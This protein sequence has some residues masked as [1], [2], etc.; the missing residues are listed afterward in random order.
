MG[1]PRYMTIMLVP[2]GTESGRTFRIR[3]WLLRFVIGFAIVL[4]VG[5]VLFFSFYGKI[6]ARAAMAD[7]LQ[8]ENQKLLRYQYKVKLLEENLVQTREVVSRLV[9][10]AGIDYEF[11]EFPSDSAIFAELDR[12]GIAVLAR[13]ADGDLTVPSGM[14]VQGFVSQDFEIDNAERF[15]PGVDIAC[16]EGTPVLATAVGEVIFADSDETYG[17]MIVIKHNDSLTTIYGH[18]KELLVGVGD[19][20]LAGSR[21]AL[22]GNTGVSTAPHL[23]YEM[24]VND[25]PINPLD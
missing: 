23:H 17:N 7:S 25:Q 1:K 18:N 13:S 11:P 3:Q 12:Q 5:I 2:D 22:S 20:V 19:K 8:D 6:L 14:P 16:A 4:V 21:I 9:E 24:R 10:L 15:H